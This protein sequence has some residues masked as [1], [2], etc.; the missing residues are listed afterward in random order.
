MKLAY[1]AYFVPSEV[2]GDWEPEFRRAALSL[3]KGAS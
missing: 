1:K 3:L 2:P